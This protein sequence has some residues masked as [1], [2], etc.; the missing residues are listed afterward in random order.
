M[1]QS[2]LK[3]SRSGKLRISCAALV[4]LGLSSCETFQQAKK[5]IAQNSDITTAGMSAMESAPKDVAGMTHDQPLILG[6]EVSSTATEDGKGNALF[7]QHITL[8]NAVPLT[9]DQLVAVVTQQTNVPIQV[10]TQVDGFLSGVQQGQQGSQMPPL[11]GQSGTVSAPSLPSVS[12]SQNQLSVDCNS[13]LRSCLDQIAAKAG[14]FWKFENGYVSFYLTDTKIFYVNALP[15]Q[16]TFNASI[17]NAGSS[18]G[19]GGGSGAS[20]GMNGATEQTA[21]VTGTLDVY[22]S[23]DDSIN[24]ILAETQSAGGSGTNLNV[25]TSV[26]ENPSAGQ[27]VVTATP[28]ELAA[29][30]QFMRPLNEDLSKNVMIDLHIYSVQLNS[31]NNYGLNLNAAFNEV[32]SRY[33]LTWSGAA[34]PTI[35]S[36]GASGSAYILSAPSAGQG[37]LTTPT[38]AVVQALATQGNVSLETEGSV[39][40]MNGQQTPLQVSQNKAY[41]ASSSVTNTVNAGSATSLTPGNYTVGFTGTFL[42]LVRGQEILLQFNANL[43][44]DLGLLTET[45]NGTTIQLPQTASQSFLQRVALHSGET[46]VLSGFEQTSDATTNNG[47]GASWFFLAGGGREATHAKQA[48]VVVIHVEDVGT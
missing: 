48:L 15:G 21:G 19:S 11:P 8:T 7:D 41:I 27:I 26:A 46:L 32:A 38:S 35:A 45:S 3:S 39:I 22:K 30:A 34:P 44:Q 42:P 1:L 13:T 18:G 40:A 36:G 33:G 14:V 17:S 12:S 24:T 10:T 16:S 2:V 20:S 9:L 23:I 25:P 37:G 28:P 47:V 29:V 5:N 6:T 43:T 31:S 4:L